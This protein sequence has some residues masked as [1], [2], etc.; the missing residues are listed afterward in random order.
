MTKYRAEH[1]AGTSQQRLA[2]LEAEKR[3][4]EQEIAKLKRQQN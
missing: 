2:T 3:K 1:P 4:I